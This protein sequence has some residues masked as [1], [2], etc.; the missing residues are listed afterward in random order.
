MPA[1]IPFNFTL[2]N[3]AASIFN[4]PS[5]DNIHEQSKNITQHLF[6]QSNH[7]HIKS[8]ELYITYL[9]S[10]SIDNNIVEAIGIFKSET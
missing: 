10:V 6:D 9:T 4:S 2:Y 5:Q 8:G 3:I 1:S 7:P